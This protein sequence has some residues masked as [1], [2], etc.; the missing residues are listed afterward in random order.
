MWRWYGTFLL[1]LLKVLV[2]L[3]LFWGETVVDRGDVTGILLLLL[4]LLAVLLCTW[5]T[6]V[7]GVWG[8]AGGV[9]D[10]W[11]VDGEEDSPKEMF[12]DFKPSI[13][14]TRTKSFCKSANEA[15]NLQSG[16]AG[17]LF[18]HAVTQSRW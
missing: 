7:C 3:L 5:D 1:L 6:S 17:V 9:D 2:L 14:A 8:V 12:K 10:I 15:F 4:L 13:I 18:I 16:H 11:G